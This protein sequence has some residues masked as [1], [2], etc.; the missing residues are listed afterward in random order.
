[1]EQMAIEVILHLL[2]EDPVL[3]EIEEL[4]NPTHQSVYLTNPRRRDGRPLHYVTEGARGLI[5]PWSR[6]SFI[7]VMGGEEA[8]EVEEFFRE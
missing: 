6:I 4:P 3:A 8:E 7:E 2:N 1:M 5:F